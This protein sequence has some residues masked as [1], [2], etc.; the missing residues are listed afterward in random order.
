MS[1]AH[2]WLDLENRP[3]EPLPRDLLEQ[4]IERVLTLTNIGFMATIGKNGPISSPVEFYTEGFDVYIYP[5][6]NSPKIKALQRDPRLSFAVANPMAGW[7]SAFGC[8]MFGN[9]QLLDAGTPEWEHG[10]TVFKY[11]SSNWEVG[12]P[13]DTVPQ[14]Q[15]LLLRPDRITLTSHFLRRD[16]YAARQF[17]D[18]DPEANIKR[19]A[20]I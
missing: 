16:G 7:A 14:G 9:A 3:T 17:W 11:P 6:P 15:L 13:I 10:M 20:S 12:R 18:R 8:Q 5:Q 19:N 2:K 4:Q 1:A